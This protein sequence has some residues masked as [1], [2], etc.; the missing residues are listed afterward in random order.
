MKKGSRFSSRLESSQKKGWAV[1]ARRSGAERRTEQGG[2][3]WAGGWKV[4]TCGVR[5][6][7]K[8]GGGLELRRPDKGL[9]GRVT[10][11]QAPLRTRHSSALTTLG[12]PLRPAHS[13]N[14]RLQLTHRKTKNFHTITK[15]AVRSS[16]PPPTHPKFQ[17]KHPIHPKPN[18]TSHPKA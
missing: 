18:P 9:V 16:L 8:A 17:N 15:L 5:S 14:K 6:G 12:A 13:E 1:G 2:R 4:A 3:R 10:A 7:A 11:G